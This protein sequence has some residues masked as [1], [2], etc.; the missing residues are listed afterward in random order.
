MSDPEIVSAISSNAVFAGLDESY[1]SAMAESARL[2]AFGPGDIICREGTE[3]DSFYILISGR[4][5]LEV[6]T[7][8]RGAMA[9]QTIGAKGIFGWSWLIPPYKWRFD[10]KALDEVRAIRIDGRWLRDTCEQDPAFGYRVL[11]RVAG[12]FA[13]RLIATRLQLLDLYGDDR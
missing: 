13:E 9:I 8:E 10:A 6:Y 11:Q 7:P 12:A 4:V 3:A 2:V 1:L 5:G